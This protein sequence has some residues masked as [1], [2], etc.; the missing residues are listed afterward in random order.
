M[1]WA[2]RRLALLHSHLDPG[3]SSANP[4]DT[5]TAALGAVPCRLAAAAGPPVVVGGMVLDLQ[6]SVP[7]SHPT[8]QTS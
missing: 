8:M 6:V 4:G 1:A 7:S 5:S 3:G 2:S